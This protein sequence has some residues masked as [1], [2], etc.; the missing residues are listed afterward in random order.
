MNS[1]V[2]ARSLN[3]ELAESLESLSRKLNL[4]LFMTLL[5]AFGALLSR[6]SG[7]PELVVGSPIAGRTRSEV[8]GLIGFFVNTLALPVSLGKKESFEDLLK[9]VRKTV[10]GAFAHQDLPF[11]KLVEELDAHRDLSREPLFQVMF[12]HQNT[13][14]EDLYLEDLEVSSLGVEGLTG[15]FDL[16]LSA[17]R[18]RKSEGGGI[19]LSLTYA[20][21]LFDGTTAHRMLA[22][23]SCLLEALVEASKS[24][25]WSLDLSSSA[26]RH[27]VV[28]EWNGALLPPVGEGRDTAYAFF[29]AQADLHPERKA[30]TRGD[31]HLTYGELNSR[32]SSLALHLRALGVAPEVPV[33]ISLP[34]EISLPVAILAVLKAGGAYVPL[35]PTYPRERLEWMIS[36]SRLP[37]ILTTGDIASSLPAEKVE[38]ILV[39]ELYESG[40]SSNQPG[41][42]PSS[43]SFLEVGPDNLSHVIYTSGST[44]RPKGVAIRHG[45]VAALL[46]W[47]R[48]AYSSQELEGVLA[49]TSLSFDLSVFE[50]LLPLSWGGR[51]LLADNALDL[52][53]ISAAG[54]V[55][56]VN[57]VPSAL[58]ELLRQE[59]I[60]RTVRTINLAGEAL[61]STLS[62]AIHGLGHVERLC[63]LYGP[64]EDTTY[65]TGSIRRGAGTPPIGRPLPGG[66]AYVLDPDQGLQ[67]FGV[68]GELLLGGEGLARG[69][70][71]RPAM[72]DERFIPDG[73]SG[74]VGERLYRTGDL[75][76]LL[77]DGNLAYLGRLDHQ[78]KVRGFRIELGEI[79][80]ILEEHSTVAEA[81]VVAVAQNLA[82]FV[83]GAERPDPATLRAYLTERL[84]SYMV[85]SFL[86]PLEE[87]PRTPNGKVDRHRLP[88][89]AGAGSAPGSLWIEPRTST[90]NLVAE[91]FK[92]LLGVEM[93]GVCDDFFHLGGHSLLATR[94]GSRL[95]GVFDV[96]I[97]LRDLFATSTVEK[98]A[99]RVDRARGGGKFSESPPLKAAPSGEFGE[100]T[101]GPLSFPQQ[102]LWFI[103]QLVPG[104]T[105][106]NIPIAVALHGPLNL[107]ALEAALDEVV[108]RHGSL[109]T[110]FSSRQGQPVQAVASLMPWSLP[111]VD[112]WGLAPGT[113]SR[114]ASRIRHR[115]AERAFDLEHGPVFR[116]F[117]LRLRSEE[118]HV[119]L[120]MHHIV[121]DGWS[122]GILVE[123]ISALYQAFSAGRPTPLSPL[124]LQ[125]VDFARWQRDWLSE[126]RLDRQVEFWREALKGAPRTLDLPLD[127][128]RPR[129]QSQEGGVV[130]R[131]LPLS[132][133]EALKEAGR[134]QGATLFMTLLAGYSL[135]LGRLADR[136]EVVVGTP[137]SGRVR[138]EVEGLIGFFINTLLLRCNLSAARA[139]VEASDQAVDAAPGGPGRTFGDLLRSLRSA[140]LDAFDHQDLPFETLVDALEP[141]R[142]LGREPFLQCVLVLQNGPRPRLRL[143]HVEAEALDAGF[144]PAKFELTLEARES[145]EGLVVTFIYSQALFDA[146]TI[147]RFAGSF[148][149]L[150][151]AAVTNPESSLSTFSLLS[152]AQRHQLRQEWS[153]A[154]S[155]EPAGK[156]QTF[157]ALFEEQAW[158][159]PR[160]IALVAGERRLTYWQVM[161]QSSA[162]ACYLE[163][164]G[165]RRG[166]L[167][168]VALD[169]CP[170]LL[171]A[172]L[173][174]LKA[175]AAYLPLD[176]TYPRARL[177]QMLEISGVPVVLSRSDLAEALPSH[178]GRTLHLDLESWETAVPESGTTVGREA[179]TLT[180][181]DLAYVIFTSGSTGA[182]KGVMVPHRHAV[183]LSLAQRR[184]LGVDHKSRVLQL[185][186][187]SF[188]ASIFD[189][190]SALAAGGSL[191]LTRPG[192]LLLGKELARTIDSEG[193][194]CLV[195]S[196]SAWST[197]PASDLPSLR[198]L[199]LAGE[200]CP[201]E[202]VDRWAPG[203]RF[204]NLYGPT[205]ATIWSTS[206]RCRAGEKR[207]SIGRAYPGVTTYV[208]DRELRLR[209]LGTVG[210]L[211]VGGSGLAWG[212]LGRPALTAERFVPNPFSQNEGSRVYRTGDRA[213]Y[214][215]IGEL[216]FLGRVDHQLKLRGFRVEPGEI[217]A[218]LESQPWVEEAVV[219]LRRDDG[220]EKGRLTAYITTVPGEAGES[221][222]H[223]E[224]QKLVSKSF[225]SESLVLEE[226]RRH[227][228]EHMIPAAVVILKSFPL[229]PSG[230][231]D[232]QA[233][234][235]PEAL[236]AHRDTEGLAPRTALELR[237]VG[238]WEDLLGRRG[239]GVRDDFFQLGGH[240]LLAVQLLA[241]LEED[242]NTVLP[243]ASLFETP[244]VE[245]Q[246]LLVE[247]SSERVPP[248]LLVPLRKEG[249]AA[250]F[251]MVHGAGASVLSYLEIVRSLDQMIP[252][253]GLEGEQLFSTLE[254]TAA[255]YLEALRK[256]H[257]EGPY[258]L[259][260]WS[261]GGVVAFEMARQLGIEGQR[262]SALVL[263][264]SW[265]FDQ[266]D[267]ARGGSPS[268]MGG[269]QRLR[270]FA[271]GLGLD[272]EAIAGPALRLQAGEMEEAEALDLLLEALAPSPAMAASLH[273]RFQAFRIQAALLEAYRPQFHPEPY[274][275][276]ALL[277]QVAMTPALA[278]DAQRRAWEKV[279]SSSMEVRI[280]PGDHYGLLQ[281]PEAESLALC[282][283]ETLQP[284]TTVKL[285]GS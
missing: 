208:A 64:S 222:E 105:A 276:P 163:S 245:G 201:Q 79:E 213:R 183:A 18:L 15:K 190:F 168:G 110:T 171:V 267:S 68:P 147:R 60:P 240:S 38:L 145:E 279:L 123:E 189:F 136:R 19:A 101:G 58:A 202:L 69:Y 20:T 34:R 121:S 138:G 221:V 284:T 52:P 214:G 227:L 165:V 44:G 192:S 252:V 76:R 42:L 285:A 282:L 32:A 223:L 261:W 265:L 241:R 130:E 166:D 127:R 55:R 151:T 59:A 164:L 36:D 83:S 210:E 181:N 114:E 258:R 275:G 90:E 253:F 11:E 154:T 207:P 117:A 283:N 204:F 85:P 143:P 53:K 203:R 112:L 95:R 187:T 160:A 71:G 146:T 274:V 266:E 108:R 182:P 153:S 31:E 14:R 3:E 57:T 77:G 235:A 116:G 65:S 133:L 142:D 234:P 186:S 51:V 22:H 262:V 106:Y 37:L 67:P 281:P 132:L 170:E 81:V 103:D 156:P 161:T 63:N 109:R 141:E 107:G 140:S 115:E 47:G 62:E 89:P 158:K 122:V 16:S 216:A 6:L 177:S 247:E 86:I 125:Y 251:F 29:E 28:R 75:V 174:I 12:L 178:G 249:T 188:D 264:D 43:H 148:E 120:S 99:A 246:A 155:L 220:G 268:E 118:H 206:R 97:P 93:V 87:L 73:L 157:H 278:R 94:L 56:L 4:T 244:T 10:K 144:T 198:T 199:C 250:P 200:A 131:H 180:P 175:G 162:L 194:T 126:E 196:P 119:L 167:V 21:A 7:Q 159:R 256:K 218:A 1:A 35:D 255:T 26:Q 212:Y 152:R 173:G 102:R 39:D 50:I 74:E 72:T 2:V 61:T 49:S 104:S 225:V 211:L 78:V 30:L 232:R 128:P 226:V 242:L 9:R 191:H 243:L 185:A 224:S 8:E 236:G 111:T 92:D 176:P 239:V 229:T 280:L 237:L 13:P 70:R 150:L 248:S 98:L 54:E 41:S 24:P 40:A 113:A 137:V 135:L 195:S 209:S 197:V 238:I 205:E 124:S 270:A 259:G 91:I 82:A 231:V 46:R 88:D 169:R 66:R 179:Q 23:W 193:I 80:S 172:F 33:G 48:E 272:R 233:L 215:A 184:L 149:A 84:P 129:L 219:L 139:T 254:E 228:P 260:G 271:L 25:V 27:Q 134:H 277:L 17:S 263:M 257:P 269:A 96:E 5:G 45:S 217:E 100:T 230:K 273:R